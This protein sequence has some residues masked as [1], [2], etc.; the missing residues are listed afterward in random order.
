MF[1]ILFQIILIIYIIFLFFNVLDLK[2]YNVKS[3]SPK[4]CFDRL[5]VIKKHQAYIPQVIH[6]KLYQSI[7]E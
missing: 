1:K 7:S 4:E 2:K 6:L 5:P 3:V